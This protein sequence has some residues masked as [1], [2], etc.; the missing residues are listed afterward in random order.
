[1]PQGRTRHPLVVAGTFADRVRTKRSLVAE[2][3]SPAGGSSSTGAASGAPS[4]A[5]DLAYAGPSV[6]RAAVMS[7]M[8]RRQC[9][10]TSG[11]SGIGW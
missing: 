4:H 10:G 11:L 7:A 8:H 3:A 9:R 6:G 2:N 5:V 1:L